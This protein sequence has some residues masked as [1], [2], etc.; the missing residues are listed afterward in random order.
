MLVMGAV[1]EGG[2]LS[3][4]IKAEKICI[5]KASVHCSLDGLLS[6]RE[7]NFLPMFS[8]GLQAFRDT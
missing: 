5:H 4:Q 7:G 8:F 2:P 6:T 1:Q 3:V